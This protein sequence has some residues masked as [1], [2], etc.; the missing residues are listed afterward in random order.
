MAFP[1]IVVIA[2]N[3]FIDDK[4]EIINRRVKIKNANSFGSNSVSKLLIMRPKSP[5]FKKSGF[6]AIEERAIESDI[7]AIRKRRVF[8]II[9][10]IFLFVKQ[11]IPIE[12]KAKLKRYE[13]NLP[14][15]VIKKEAIVTP[16]LPAIFWGIFAK[17]EVKKALS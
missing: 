10:P 9:L 2:L 5:V 17:F 3:N 16:N 12:K 11:L 13:E 8:S 15:S 4:S 7:P 1:I 14:Y 6:F